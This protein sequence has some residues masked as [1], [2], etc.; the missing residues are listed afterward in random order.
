MSTKGLTV[1]E[2]GRHWTR[3]KAMFKRFL[4][5][6]IGLVALLWGMATPDQAY[7]Q[8]FR[9]GFRAS[10]FRPMRQ[11]V[12]MQRHGFGGAFRMHPGAAFGH[13]GGD[14]MHAT[15]MHSSSM[16]QPRM[17]TPTM[18]IPSMNMPTMNMPTMNMPTMNMPTMNM[19]TMNMPMR[20]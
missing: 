3:R 14:M 18:N 1:L 6:G 17:N 4:F 13:R 16:Q 9:G 10:G 12:G 15:S 19:P 7:A 8:G 20:R 11:N 5:L 2:F